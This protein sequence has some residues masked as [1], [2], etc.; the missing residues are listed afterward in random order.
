[1]PASE[2]YCGQ[3]TDNRRELCDIRFDYEAML[4]AKLAMFSSEMIR[5]VKRIGEEAATPQLGYQFEEGVLNIMSKL[6]DSSSIHENMAA[7]GCSLSDE[8]I[9]QKIMIRVGNW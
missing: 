5:V 8:E 2:A 4:R 6:N 7:V 1:M 3:C 9:D